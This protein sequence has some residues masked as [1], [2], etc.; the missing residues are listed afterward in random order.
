MYENMLQF[1]LITFQSSLLDCTTWHF[2]D[3]KK[4]LFDS[5]AQLEKQ[6]L[7]PP[8][9]RCKIYSLQLYRGRIQKIQKGVAG[10][11][12]SSIL[13]TFYFF[14]TEFFGPPL[15]PPMFID[16]VY[17]LPSLPQELKLKKSRSK[18]C[19]RENDYKRT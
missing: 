16:S 2:L 15:N 18:C 5:W 11:L 1:P 17:L 13:N 9:C 6:S 10:T 4:K 12:N 14:E 7:L 19:V 8:L 3:N